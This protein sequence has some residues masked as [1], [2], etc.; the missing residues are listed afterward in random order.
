MIIWSANFVTSSALVSACPNYKQPEF[1]F[2]GRSNVGKSSFIN[3]LTNKKNLAKVSGT[4]GK[5]R[6]INHFI[7]NDHWYL[8]DLP[9]YGFA[10]IS[11]PE[12]EKLE[13]LIYSYF[14]R[15]R[16]LRHTYVL[17]DSRLDPQANDIAFMTWLAL[18]KIHFTV[19]FTKCDK[20]NKTKLAKNVR[21][22]EN[23][24]N[25]FDSCVT[26]LIPTSIISKTGK[27][28]VLKSL[29]QHLMQ[30]HLDELPDTP[31]ED[32]AKLK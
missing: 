16:N 25:E 11:K 6:L 15:R 29:E 7:I 30:N 14:K 2:I 4:P 22:F 24:F 13:K 1:A 9:G 26:G 31:D 20:V 32:P 8:V 5:T 12:R 28:E 21:K 17:I 19:L 3:M 10:R 18:H 27:T 23:I